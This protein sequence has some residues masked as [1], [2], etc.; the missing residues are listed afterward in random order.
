MIR[1]VGIGLQ[2]DIDIG[3]RGEHLGRRSIV[4]S[5]AL[6]G[7]GAYFSAHVLCE[8]AHFAKAKSDCAPP[9]V[10]VNRPP[11]SV[12]LHKPCALRKRGLDDCGA[13]V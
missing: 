13:F 4:K 2:N 5:C 10:Q 11:D 8:M 12:Y 6:H 9:I 7:R 3:Y 1:R